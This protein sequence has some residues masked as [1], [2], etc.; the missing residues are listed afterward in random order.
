MVLSA[1]R[2]GQARIGCRVMK[3][4]IQIS[5]TDPRYKGLAIQTLGEADGMKVVELLSGPVNDLEEIYGISITAT[6]SQVNK[7]VDKQ[8]LTGLAQLAGQ[9][10]P[11]L[12][13]YAQAMAQLKQDPTILSATIESAYTGQL[14]L[15]RRVLEAFDIQNPEEYI[16]A[17]ATQVQ[18]AQAAVPGGPGMPGAPGAGPPQ[19]GGGQPPFAPAAQ[20]NDV[21]SQVLG[22]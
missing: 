15:Y 19:M 5:K 22:L 9:M 17:L 12:V 16:P 10:Y 11:A 4:V 6:S 20:G 2:E 1:L 7:E 13:Q 21:L 18:A 8:S 14:E 3:N